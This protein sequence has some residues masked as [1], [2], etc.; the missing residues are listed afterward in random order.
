MT[1][2]LQHIGL[3]VRI[4]EG[5]RGFI[6]GVRIDK[7]RLFVDPKCPVSGLLHEAGHLAIV[8]AQFRP[9]L[10]GDLRE[11][12]LRMFE[13]LDRQGLD[14]DHPLSRAVVQASDP[15]AT[16]WAW[17][18]GEHL[19]IPPQRRILDAEYEGT[20]NIVRFQLQRCAYLGI[21]G[22]SHAGF[23]ATRALLAKPEKP[24]YPKL[25]FWTQP[26]L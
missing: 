12:F 13:E 7:G 5:A 17:A 6:D 19:G 23:C 26:V 9:H 8:P 3:D 18:A 2:F 1:A 25:A 14:P 16:A 24:A 11:A 22:L 20:G 4:E 15:E 10:S 21:H